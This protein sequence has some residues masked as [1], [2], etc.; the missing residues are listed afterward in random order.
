[1]NNTSGYTL[2]ETVTVMC[3][4]TALTAAGIP[5]LTRHL[6][7]A[8]NNVLAYNVRVL[9][10][11][12][13]IFAVLGGSYPACLT[14]LVEEGYLYSLPVNPWTRRPDFCYDPASGKIRSAP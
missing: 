13:E 12:V 9:Q 10:Q 1:M 8:K 7:T 2:L 4:V 5:P 14:E 6:D 11:T 3:L